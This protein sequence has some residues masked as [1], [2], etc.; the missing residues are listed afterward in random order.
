MPR[1]PGFV[2]PRWFT[3]SLLSL[4]LNLPLVLSG[5]PFSSFDAYTHIF[6]ADHYRRA[7]FD[8]VEPRWFGGFS[9][10]SYPPLVHQLIAL[11]SLPASALASMLGGA[12]NET[13]FRGEA[14]GFCLLLLL[15]LAFLPMAT[16]R[17]AAIFVPA[18]AAR[19]A[20][21][22]TVGLP[23]IYL[24]AYS[25]GQLPT[26]AATATLMWALAEGWRFCQTGQRRSLFSAILWAGVTAAAHHAVLLFA[27]VAGA[28]IAGR[29][30]LITLITKTQRHDGSQRFFF[31]FVKLSVFVPSW[32]RVAVRLL[33]WAV[34]AGLFAALVIWPF[35]AWS[36][37]Y[38][39]QTP[40]DH[41]S[42]HNY[43]T[44]WLAAYF[45]FW[46]MYGPTLLVLPLSALWLFR[47]RRKRRHWPLLI[48][49]FLLFTLGLGGTTPLPQW[50]FGANWAWLTY[51]RFSFW[52]G[53][54]LLPFAGLLWEFYRGQFHRKDAK[55]AKKTDFSFLSAK[56]SV[57]PRPKCLST[58]NPVG[59]KKEKAF[60]LACPVS[61]FGVVSLRLILIAFCL[62]AAFAARWVKSQPPPVDLAAIA[63]F[64]DRNTANGER[65]LT[66]GF[67]DQLARLSVL[68][69]ARTID[70]T[71]FTAREI[72][73]LRRS[74]LGAL[75]GALW[76][77]AGPNSI[78]PFL[79]RAQEW[80]VR[81]AF[82]MHPAYVEPLIA[83]GWQLQ[84]I[85]A[86]GVQVWRNPALRVSSEWQA[87]I[88]VDYQAGLWWGIVP[89]LVLAMA[90]LTMLARRH[91][92]N[93]STLLL[94]S[95]LV[96][97]PFWHYT[98]IWTQPRPFVYF[99]YTSGLL[100]LADL[101][102]GALV[103]L[104]IYNARPFQFSLSPFLPF[105]LPFF[106]LIIFAF[107][108]IPDSVAPT[109][110]L[111]FALHLIWLGFAA[112][113]V[114]QTMK[115]MDWRVV[116]YA[117]TAGLILQSAIAIAESA[118]QTTAWLQPLGLTWPGELVASMRGASVVGLP[119]GLRW[120]RAYGTLPHPNLLAGYLLVTLAGPLMGYIQTGRKRWLW[121][122][123]F[124]A[125]ALCL[126]FSRAGWLACGA[127]MASLIFL[128][129]SNLRRRAAIVLAV[130]ALVSA[131]LVAALGPLFITRLTASDASREETISITTRQQ[132]NDAA[133]TL[134]KWN[135]INGV[136]A[137]AFLPAL[138]MFR[139][140][141]PEP[142][143]NVLLL[144][145]AE[146]GAGGGLAVV[147]LGSM[148]L[149]QA[150]RRRG[151]VVFAALS[152]IMVGLMVMAMFDHFLWS[153]SPGRTLAAVVMGMWWGCKGR[154]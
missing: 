75:D 91:I 73:E 42:R 31:G 41:A 132:L 89:L 68:T 112:Q 28:A 130:L 88:N 61:F 26:L 148:I 10:A 29:A 142:A 97:W 109:L 59:P 15:V 69:E 11:L 128:L 56:I 78:Q 146:T 111:G 154:S 70:G 16:E 103:V 147:A 43:L 135:P 153:L 60:A 45:F 110:S 5:L 131:T 124:G 99:T 24:T 108:S 32:L 141:A 122:L 79:A 54:A 93:G 139:N 118:T 115:L 150:W 87:P 18:R 4:G 58:P 140:L 67:G 138:V 53:L 33:I 100:F 137:G 145:L 23:S 113:A 36:R 57:H 30:L 25:F 134:F 121:P 62:Y 144:A 86:S 123:A 40:I 126:T 119:N 77:P 76:N 90:L 117:L 136:G 152:A 14:V 13:R 51:D 116:A 80:G 37:G 74:G 7:W 106:A 64:L 92:L 38:T 12:Q 17:F 98:T 65:Y 95:F 107:L 19:T 20:G 48:V 143:H 127:A 8:L 105:S 96:L 47:A 55:N 71:Y 83:S 49:A 22:L 3:P 129:P 82:N 34:S 21:W 85:V 1:T 52:A 66:F 6:F 114:S 94:S 84:G 120:L 44:D 27:L 149:W 101:L 2:F 104:V 63:R 50:L 102:I 46:P 72:P 39:P 133:L 151:E 125:G 9:V 81:W 35:I